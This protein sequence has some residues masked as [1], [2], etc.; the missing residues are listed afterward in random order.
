MTV[1]V[2]V[3]F[4]MGVTDTVL[5]TVLAVA[6]DSSDDCCG[7]GQHIA[8]GVPE[9]GGDVDLVRRSAD[10]ER[11]RSGD[12]AVSR[13]RAILHR[14]LEL[15]G[16]GQAA[17]IGGSDRDRGGALGD[18]RDRHRAPGSAGR[19]PRTHPTTLPSRSGHRRRGR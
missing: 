12:G 15:L 19:W 7:V 2:A 6:T 5:P 8:V 14:H 17:R 11:R 4:A 18:R 16:S 3:P 13:R 10:V 1:I 9:V